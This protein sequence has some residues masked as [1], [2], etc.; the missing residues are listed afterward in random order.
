VG[1]GRCTSGRD[2]QPG[3][4]PS[5][6]RRMTCQGARPREGPRVSDLRRDGAGHRC[7]GRANSSLRRQD[8]LGSGRH[9]LGHSQFHGR[10][11]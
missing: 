6:C 4:A 10:G 2:A 8:R 7:P 9:A 5:T 3:V 1:R 11:P